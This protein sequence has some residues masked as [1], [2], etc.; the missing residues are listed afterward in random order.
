[1]A[2][3]TNLLRMAH[4]WTSRT[5]SG[6]TGPDSCSLSFLLVT[7]DWAR[8]E[9]DAAQAILSFQREFLQG[10]GSVDA[11]PAVAG[12]R[13]GEGQF[14]NGSAVR[15]GRDPVTSAGFLAATGPLRSFAD[16]FELDFEPGS[17]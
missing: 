11:I 12:L 8:E 17:R 10:A 4:T 2:V 13:S 15:Q 9:K 5:E 3:G 7:H 16:W 1:M 6:T 14:R